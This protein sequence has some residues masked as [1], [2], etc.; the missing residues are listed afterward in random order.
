[1]DGLLAIR[2]EI[3]PETELEIE[4]GSLDGEE[5]GERESEFWEDFER[6]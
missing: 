4:M 1:M 5:R 2:L 3:M 6:S